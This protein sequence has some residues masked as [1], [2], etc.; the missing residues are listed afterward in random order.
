MLYVFFL[1]CR[2]L[3]ALISKRFRQE[4]LEE[5]SMTAQS[6]SEGTLLGIQGSLN[7]RLNRLLVFRQRHI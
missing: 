6:K 2:Q 3:T 4:I 7:Y 1:N 5:E